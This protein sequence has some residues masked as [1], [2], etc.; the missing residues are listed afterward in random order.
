M[1]RGGKKS[2]W[3]KLLPVTLFLLRRVAITWLNWIGPE[4]A[5]VVVFSRN[6]NGDTIPYGDWV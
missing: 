2:P 4:Q 5:V 6:R 1:Y 3:D